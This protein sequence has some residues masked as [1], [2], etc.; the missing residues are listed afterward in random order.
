MASNA[1]ISDLKKMILDLSL[2]F[3]SVSEKIDNIDTKFGKMLT[4]VKEDVEKIKINITNTQKEIND[5]KQDVKK[6]WDAHKELE[7]GVQSVDD[8]HTDLHNLEINKLER[9]KSELDTK[10]RD[11]KV[12]HILQEKHD[13]KYNVLVY[14]IPEKKMGQGTPG[15]NVMSVARNF[16]LENLQI[17]KDRVDTL[18]LA[19]V[20]RIP[21]RTTPDR[22]KG[23]DPILIRFLR[24]SDKELVMYMAKN[25]LKDSKIRVLDDLPPAMKEARHN[26]A[27]MAYK[28]RHEEK[29]QTRIRVKDIKVILETRMKNNSSDTWQLRKEIS[30]V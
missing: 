5:T 6:L 7:R 1:D 21:S 11:L 19:N 27:N 20:H 8:T 14:G 24:W 16:F 9:A 3:N 13:R 12:Q 25:K 10:I 26:L 2:K 4:E 30:A 28:I 29:L 23:P 15:E 18:V 17:V 22:P